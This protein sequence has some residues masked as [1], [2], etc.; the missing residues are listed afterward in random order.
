MLKEFLHCLEYLDSFEDLK[1]FHKKFSK[2]KKK[3]KKESK[4]PFY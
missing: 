3:S 4:H 1:N 2:S